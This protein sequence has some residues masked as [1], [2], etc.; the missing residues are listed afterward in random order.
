MLKAL[1]YYIKKPIDSIDSKFL[2]KELHKFQ[3]QSKEAP[4][5]KFQFQKFVHDN[6]QKLVCFYY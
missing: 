3:I 5:S 1:E 4:G 6:V 2:F